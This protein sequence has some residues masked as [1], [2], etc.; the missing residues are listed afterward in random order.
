MIHLFGGVRQINEVVLVLVLLPEQPLIISWY[1]AP[2]NFIDLLVAGSHFDL[3]LHRTHLRVHICVPQYNFIIL[4]MVSHIIRQLVPGSWLGAKTACDQSPFVHLQ[5]AQEAGSHLQ[6]GSAR[7]QKLKRFHYAPSE[8]SHYVGRNNE[9]G[10]ILRFNW[11]NQYTFVVFN[12]LLDE[13]ENLVWNLLGWVEQ[14]LLLVVL[15]VESEVE[16]AN[17]LP[18]I[19]QLSACSV[20]DPRYFIGN[21]KLE[22]LQAQ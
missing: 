5:L 11:L 2:L 13:F 12:S 17:R 22:I 20:D 16:N 9:T 3:V 21:N 7:V 14:C 8:L 18:K 4:Q 1:I 15:P 10:P 6:V 19:A